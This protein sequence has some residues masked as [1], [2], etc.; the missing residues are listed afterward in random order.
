MASSRSDT[1]V[2]DPLDNTARSSSPIPLLSI[3]AWSP[4]LSPSTREDSLALGLDTDLP[5]APGVNVMKALR[6]LCKELAPPIVAPEPLDGPLHPPRRLTPLPSA[7]QHGN[8]SK[9]KRSKKESDPTLLLQDLVS[10]DKSVVSDVLDRFKSLIVTHDPFPVDSNWQILAQRANADICRGIS[11][12]LECKPGSEY[13]RLV[14]YI[15]FISGSS[16][17][18]CVPDRFSTGRPTYATL[19]SDQ[20]LPRLPRSMA[21]EFYVEMSHQKNAKQFSTTTWHLLQ[22]YSRRLTLHAR[23]AQFFSFFLRSNNQSSHN[24]VTQAAR[25]SL[26]TPDFY[27]N[28]SKIVLLNA[29][30]WWAEAL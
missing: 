15:L 27:E 20:P 21:S 11:N 25:C 24:A 9:S 17:V 4:P 29:A 28:T 13:E 10:E 26:R 16:S 14:G 8:S 19:L 18:T 7:P 12:R 5:S 6:G 23:C 2:P 3:H 22:S 1:P 30:G